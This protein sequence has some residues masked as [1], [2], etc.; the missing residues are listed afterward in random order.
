M[1]RCALAHWRIGALAH[2]R[3]GAVRGSDGLK[4]ATRGEHVVSIVWFLFYAVV[5]A[6]LHTD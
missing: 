5:Q 3:I 1:V 2:W 6:H 4:C